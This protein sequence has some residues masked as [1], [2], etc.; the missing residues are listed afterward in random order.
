VKNRFLFVTCLLAGLSAC[1]AQQN[2]T[3]LKNSRDFEVRVAADKLPAGATAF[4]F[5]AAGRLWV[6]APDEKSEFYPGA[7]KTS[8]VLVYDVKDG[9]AVSPKAF[10]NYLKPITSFVFYKDG[11]IVAQGPSIL[12]LRDKNQNGSMDV[13]ELLYSGFATNDPSGLV[14]NLRWGQD[15][16]IYA[17]QNNRSISDQV[18]NRDG[19]PMGSV[20]CSV[21]RFRPDGQAVEKVAYSPGRITG[22]DVAS[23]G[24]IFFIQA[25]APHLQHIV[26]EECYLE[27]GRLAK[28]TSSKP[29]EDHRSLFPAG[30]ENVTNQVPIGLRATNAAGFA[31]YDGGAWPLKFNGCQFLGEP[32]LHV[33]HEDIVSAVAE[34]MGYEATRRDLG[35]FLTGDA[36]FNPRSLQI[37]LDG[38]LYILDSGAGEQPSKLWRVQH[39]QAQKWVAEDLS[40][41]PV[42]ALAK[43]LEHP[44]KKVRMTV[45]RRIMEER[46]Q[47][48]VPALSNLLHTARLPYTRAQALWGLYHLGALNDS[49]MIA[50]ITDTHPA[51][52]KSAFRI[53][54][55]YHAPTN[56]PLEKALSKVLGKDL[57]DRS[58]LRAILAFE[59]P[60]LTK[61][62]RGAL[63]K[64]SA[65]FKDLWARSAALS[66]LRSTPL[67]SLKSAFGSEKADAL[68]DFVGII[69]QDIAYSEN[70]ELAAQIVMILGGPKG[71][72]S[73]TLK[74]AV[75]ESFDR[76]LSPGFIPEWS[77]D[78]GKALKALVG[79]Q[80][81][82]VR[83]AALP[84]AVHW[85]T[86]NAIAPKI[87][88][89]KKD[90]F[91]DIES[92]KLTDDQRSKLIIGL[93]KI[94]AWE[95]DVIPML[96][97]LLD[98]KMGEPIQKL[99]LGELANAQHPAGADVIFRRYP[100]I[101]QENRSLA[102]YPLLRKVDQCKALLE[103][104]DKK[105]VTAQELG[106]HIM[107]VLVHYP[108]P[109][110]ASLA[111]SIAERAKKGHSTLP[112]IAAEMGN[113]ADPKKGK[114]LFQKNCGFC[115]KVGSEGKELGPDVSFLAL[116]E[117]D[118]WLEN[119]LGHST[120]STEPDR[121]YFV[122]TRNEEYFFGTILR[123][124]ADGIL[125]RNWQEDREIRTSE[126]GRIFPTK[127]SLMPTSLDILDGA[128]LRDIAAFIKVSIKKGT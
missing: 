77:E 36:G 85:D 24:E 55:D 40:K 38:A 60:G 50:G 123:H 103:A 46:P 41:L 94:P 79:S 105:R 72:P 113:K 80:S 34:G 33:I 59:R 120:P 106:A 95:K 25:R 100:K 117:P 43:R 86:S 81:H 128:V 127:N 112:E 114:E 83:Y 124:T 82:T 99:L 69:A 11:I 126:I 47:E 6:V 66:A 27:R 107:D 7:A 37:G 26:M 73:D 2:P 16:W 51:V 75:L 20:G 4:D 78:L 45:G 9:E 15:G 17:A 19:Q 104:V 63:V 22:L 115:H 93:M 29:I 62:G 70:K 102:V 10:A 122:S 35:E 52:Q 53:V 116:V 30:T 48:I 64:A 68:K 108:D 90:F 71:A 21:F 54:L 74:S 67:E 5:D 1:W 58:K 13:Q 110:V 14:D 18:V 98:I 39:R 89:A 121:L 97:K 96:D 61:E 65:D 91:A 57:D 44:N 125:L 12:W 49:N 3:N 56:S 28:T 8:R 42:E 23:D 92:K 119:V 32:S 118:E 87:A 88:S 84:L 109:E 111:R 31:I 101:A 76:N